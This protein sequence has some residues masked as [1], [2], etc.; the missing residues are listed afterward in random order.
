MTD[1][2]D[3]AHCNTAHLLVHIHPQQHHQAGSTDKAYGPFAQMVREVLSS[4]LELAKQ[5]RAQVEANAKGG[6]DASVPTSDN[7][8]EGLEM[9][10]S[11]A[12]ALDELQHGGVYKGEDVKAFY[13]E[14]SFDG[15]KQ[16]EW[17]AQ[18]PAVCKKRIRIDPLAAIVSLLFLGAFGFYVA[19]RV[20]FTLPGLGNYLAYGIVVLAVECLGAMSLVPYALTIMW[21]TVKEDPPSTT[22]L[23]Y[24]VCGFVFFLLHAPHTSSPA[25]TTYLCTPLVPRCVC[26]SPATASHSLWWGKQSLLHSAPLCPLAAAKHSTCATMARIPTSVHSARH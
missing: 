7:A 21:Y 22:T 2:G 13:L 20:I 4:N 15:I 10:P 18:I 16:A 14:Q 12:K 23:H 8:F 25:C 6:D 19:W 1:A 5:L 3:L 17:D 11:L 9:S 24:H 26:S